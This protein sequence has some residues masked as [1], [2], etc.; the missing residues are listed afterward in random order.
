MTLYESLAEADPKTR[1]RLDTLLLDDE[2]LILVIQQGSGTPDQSGILGWLKGVLY[3][4]DTSYRTALTD[5]RLIRFRV[6]AFRDVDDYQLD[7]VSTVDYDFG[8][9]PEIEI[10]GSG[11]EEDFRVY[12]ADEGERLA[13]ELRAQLN[14]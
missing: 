13:N 6:G 3:K 9:R 2:K 10:S 8:L 11:I 14:S 1:E 7:S 5:K 12:D 4:S